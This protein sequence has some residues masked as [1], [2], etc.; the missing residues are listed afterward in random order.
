MPEVLGDF[1]KTEDLILW[2][3]VRFS[4]LYEELQTVQGLAKI[5]V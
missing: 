2:A 3:I 5:V 1:G 4:Q